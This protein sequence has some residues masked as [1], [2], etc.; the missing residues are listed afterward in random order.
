MDA[1]R[2][3][4]LLVLLILCFFVS[5]PSGAMELIRDG[6]ILYA[7]GPIEKGDVKK[8]RKYIFDGRKRNSISRIE[9][10]SPGGNLEEA[11]RIGR[12]IRSQEPI[13]VTVSPENMCASSCLMLLAGAKSRLIFK[14]AR[15]Y[16][17]RPYLDAQTND[18]DKLI[19]DVR[20][21]LVDYL[22]EMNVPDSLAERMMAIP[23]D[24]MKLLTR[25]E[26]S[27][28][29][30]DGDDPGYKQEKL[31]ET[32]RDLGINVSELIYRRQ[33]VDTI[34][35][36]DSVGRSSHIKQNLA[37]LRYSMC[38]QMVESTNVPLDEIQRRVKYL[39][40]NQSYIEALPGKKRKKCVEGVI[41]R[42]N[43]K[44]CSMDALDP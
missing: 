3:L 24:E 34:C 11:M 14:N 15:I 23:P 18:Y 35:K 17:H 28:Y 9:L 25:E 32:A 5:T 1:R 4:H 36:W 8:F 19:K 40:E 6:V 21:E 7:S 37:W 43:S 31:S 39:E 22:R 42:G 16:I 2:I 27:R 26:L 12:F 13:T 44:R 41:F 10:N 38:S 33:N 30:L 29:M 20:G